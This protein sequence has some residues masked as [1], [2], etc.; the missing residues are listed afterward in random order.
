L[1]L[2][3]L[4]TQPQ[5]L[6]EL[7][8]PSELPPIAV[9]QLAIDMQVAPT[10]L[11]QELATPELSAALWLVRADIAE[12]AKARQERQNLQQNP[13][14][15]QHTEKAARPALLEQA[16]SPQQQPRVVF[17]EHGLVE[18]DDEEKEQEESELF[19]WLRG[20]KISKRDC[21]RYVRSL[22]ADGYDTVESVAEMVQELAMIS[23][24]GGTNGQQL[25]TQELVRE[26]GLRVGHAKRV[27]KAAVQEQQEHS[28][29]TAAVRKPP[30]GYD[31]FEVDAAGVYTGSVSPAP[32]LSFL[33][34]SED[35]R[36][37][38]DAL[39][40]GSG[41]FGTVH[42][43]VWRG[44]RVAVKSFKPGVR[45][46]MGENFQRELEVVCTLRHPRICQFLGASV[47]R[48]REFILSELMAG[49][50]Y[51]WLHGTNDASELDAVV[52]K[53]GP[54]G[55]ISS[56]DLDDAGYCC[57]PDGLGIV[58]R[59]REPLSAEQKR[60]IARDVSC[61]V[62]YLHCEGVLHR[63]LTTRNILLDEHGRAKVSDFGLA[64]Q[65]VK[66]GGSDDAP[67]RLLYEGSEE[68]GNGNLLYAAPEVLR[69]EVCTASSDI[70]SFG[71]CMWEMWS[72]K[73]PFDGARADGV[74]V[75]H[76]LLARVGEGALDPARFATSGALGIGAA[77][78]ALQAQ[79]PDPMHQQLIL[80]CW[81]LVPSDR[82]LFGDIIQRLGGE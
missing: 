72:G 10:A 7:P 29:Q 11:Q 51:D 18:D 50:L 76:H 52:E 4:G 2:S 64:K 1:S 28:G 31:P 24:D 33:V 54:V 57:M 67:D 74:A 53:G 44:E 68:T 16:H 22:F 59:Y 45:K 13:Q 49:S 56:A 63:D 75:L 25:R 3:P 20:L 69:G 77:T 5:V 23:D 6:S 81:E 47:E 39:P 41:F 17:H 27:I 43:G 55:A 9:E 21:T 60:R 40:L 79:I 19:A 58:Q 12:D 78:T 36:Q 34:H 66:V 30:S 38:K 15:Q 46:G 73:K 8:N 48:G 62:Y 61:G 14:K 71:S 35:V 80:Q 70:Y 37:E 65:V 42:I 82:P 32:S 26:Y